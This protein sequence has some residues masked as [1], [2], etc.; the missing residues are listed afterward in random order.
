MGKTVTTAKFSE[1]RGLDRISTTVHAMHCIYREIAKDDFG[2][3]AEIEV[4]VLKPNGQSYETNGGIV[5]VQAKS[6][7]KYVVQDRPD[8][9]ATP[10]ERNDLLTWNSNT[11]PVIFIVYHP[12]D[13]RLYWKDV[14]AYLKTT[15]LAFQ[16]PVRLLFDKAADV[17]DERSYDSLCQLSLASPPRISYQQRERLF[18][19]LLLV[20]RTPLVMT[21]AA[22]PF[23]NEQAIREQ[24][25]RYI[26]PFCLK[27][28]RIYTLADL[29]D[30]QCVFRSLCDTTSIRD[31]EAS[32][33]RDDTARARDY[34]YLLNQ[35][36]SSHLRRCGLRYH[37]EFRRYYF[38]RPDENLQ[39]IRRD[40]INV[41]TGR[42]SERTVVKYYQYGN[43]MFWRHLAAELTFVRMGTSVYLQILPKY[44][45]T[46]DGFAPS[47]PVLVGP[48]TTRIKAVERNIHVLNH[49]L[50]WADVLAQRGPSIDMLL[51]FQT[52]LSIEKTP[53]S[54][55]APFAIPGDP[56]LYEEPTALGQLSLFDEYGELLND[57]YYV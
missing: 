5:K 34:I 25:Q 39:E 17:F 43:A 48:Y 16:S 36:L 35:L 26:P 54:G 37:R 7:E 53:L 52:V 13:D 20:K 10:V 24:V 33:W 18:S 6:G 30:P 45:F 3:D 2:I 4:A 57:D 40:W 22:T 19:N 11:F 42:S 44:L 8:S 1:W 9:F 56:A 41:R 55:V 28:G 50:F 21:H 27:E 46:V 49:I 31:M 15:S 47:D 32:S 12:K 23:Q 51:N 38:P 29:R 14:K